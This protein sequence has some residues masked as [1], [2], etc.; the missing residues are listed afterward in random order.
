ML[1]VTHIFIYY[2]LVIYNHYILLYIR[3]DTHM[4][5]YVYIN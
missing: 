5:I 3:C 2:I 4:Q 1:D